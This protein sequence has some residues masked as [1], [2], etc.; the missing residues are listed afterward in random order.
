[1]LNDQIL[2]DF[3]KSIKNLEEALNSEKTDINRDASI[4]RFELCFDLSWKIIKNYAKK[5][6]VECNSPRSCIKTAFQLKLI[7]YD[8]KWIKMI[9]DRNLTVH[10]YK[11]QYANEVYFRFPDY[12]NLFKK[13][14][15][16]LKQSK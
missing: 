14:F 13:L 1:M 12:L 10:I 8:E 16:Q 15:I 11:E 3:E 7:D 4:K 5:E 2:K 9:E 6:G